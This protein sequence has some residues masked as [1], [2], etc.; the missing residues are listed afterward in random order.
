[1]HRPSLTSPSLVHVKSLTQRYVG[2]QS[3]PRPISDNVVLI[4]LHQ[5]I[6]APDL[7]R[8]Q[9]KVAVTEGDE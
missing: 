2:T 5:D 8:T 1:M 6:G 7:S 4:P 9:I 3:C